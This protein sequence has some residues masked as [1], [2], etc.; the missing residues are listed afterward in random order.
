MKAPPYSTFHSMA[1]ALKTVLLAGLLALLM[2]FALPQPSEANPMFLAALPGFKTMFSGQRP[3]NIG[4]N[5]GKLAACPASPNC[6]VSQGADDDHDIA[7]LTFTGDGA[8]AMATLATVVADQPRNQ[9][10]QQTDD[11]LYFEFSSR[12]MGFVDDVEFYLDADAGVIQMRAAARLGQ[13]DLGV[14]RDRLETIRAAFAAAQ[15]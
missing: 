9:L 1:K 6:V 5:G 8:A 10:I 12:L 2:G 7:P 3:S 11:Y 13:S 4:V 14:N 15:A